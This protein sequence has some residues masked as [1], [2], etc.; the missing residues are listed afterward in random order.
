M[1]NRMLGY[2]DSEIF[3]LGLLGESNAKQSLAKLD[4]FSVLYVDLDNLA[5]D[6]SFDLIHQLHGLYDAQN[7]A[8]LN[9]VTCLDKRLGIRIWRTVKRSNNW[10]PH[11]QETF[12]F[13][14]RHGNGWNTGA[15]TSR[16]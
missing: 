6:F 13:I 2:R 3:G 9:R 5:A 15:G 14:W 7:P 16:C 11:V 1:Q 8:R 4:G 12:V 10:R